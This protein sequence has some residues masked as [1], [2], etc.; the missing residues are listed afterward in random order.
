[1][2]FRVCGQVGNECEN[3]HFITG[4]F[5]FVMVSLAKGRFAAQPAISCQIAANAWLADR[6]YGVEAGVDEI[7]VRPDRNRVL[8]QMLLGVP[9]RT[10]TF[11]PADS[12]TQHQESLFETGAKLSRSSANDDA[13]NPKTF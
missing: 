12:F 8:L 4:R 5:L 3:F 1:M 2:A 13:V 10:I 9:K 7:P 6:G 11:V